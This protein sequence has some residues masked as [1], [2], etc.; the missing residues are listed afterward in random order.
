V[1]S[2]AVKVAYLVNRY[3]ATSHTFIRREIQALEALDVEVARFSLRPVAAKELADAADREEL[4]KTRAVLSVGAVGLARAFLRA[5]VTRPARL[6]RALAL[7]ARV[8]RR[9][10]RGLVNHLAYLVEACVLVGWLEEVGARHVHAHFGTNST[11]VAMLAHELGGPPF[12]FTMHHGTKEIFGTGGVG[13]AEKVKHSRFVS[14]VSSFGR[15]EVYHCSTPDEWPKVHVVRCGLDAAYLEAAPTPIPEAPR[16]VCVGR[17]APQKGQV[18]LLEAAARLAAQGVPFE[19]VLVGDGE[20]RAT[21]EASIASH[22]LGARVRIT[23]WADG[24]AVRRE[25]LAARAFVLPSFSEG[26]PVAI[27]EAYALGRPV[28]STYVAGIP[29][30]VEPGRTG[31]LVPAGDVDGLERALREVLAAPTAQLAAMADAGRRRVRDEHD[32]AKNARLLRDL[33][34]ASGEGAAA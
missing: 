2:P 3:P 4:G 17:L 13:P 21:I 19:I 27:M 24:E 10:E 23:G 28:V 12:S 6:A 20:M 25:I 31:W 22:G 18:I 1:S 32:C 7:A 34:A 30:L 8:G 11:T 15:S 16:L 14:A 9:S 26:L 29:E 5:L 33:F